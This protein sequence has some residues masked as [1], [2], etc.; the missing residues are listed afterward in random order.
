[1]KR[2]IDFCFFHFLLSFLKLLSVA[3]IWAGI[4][5]WL[6]RYIKLFFFVPN[7]IALKA[8]CLR[9]ISFKCFY[10]IRLW[11][12][13]CDVRMWKMPSQREFQCWLCVCVR[14]I[15]WLL[16]TKNSWGRKMR[17]WSENEQR[18]KYERAVCF[19]Y[20]KID[21]IVFFGLE[22]L[23]SDG[24]FPC[25]VFTEVFPGILSSCLCLNQVCDKRN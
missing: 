13:N 11:L 1:M 6:K 22:N 20:G 4:V 9:Y 18:W 19:V 8:I 23:I 12:L 7:A 15:F 10:S 24:K 25:N 2:F 16:C 14:E 17:R 21:K 3:Q 5:G